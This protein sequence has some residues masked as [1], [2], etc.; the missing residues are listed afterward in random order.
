MIP[1]NTQ[2]L[3]ELITIRASS[4]QILLRPLR[5]LCKL[6]GKKHPNKNRRG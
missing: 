2:F 5:K 4:Q 3:C 6:R 1:N